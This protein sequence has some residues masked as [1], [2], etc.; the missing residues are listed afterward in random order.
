[1]ENFGSD[2]Q[3]IPIAFACCR[4]VNKYE[5]VYEY[6]DYHQYLDLTIK[7]MIF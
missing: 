3:S 6:E 4:K 7:I 5:Y 2:L 1:M